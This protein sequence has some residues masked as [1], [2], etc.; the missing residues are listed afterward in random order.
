MELTTALVDWVDVDEQLFLSGGGAEDYQYDQRRDR[1]TARNYFA[2]TPQELRLV[3]GMGDD[4]W[5]SFGDYLT[6]YGPCKLNLAAINQDHW[7]LVEAI[8]RTFAEPTDPVAR[9]ERKLEV[10]AQFVTPMLAYSDSGSATGGSNPNFFAGATGGMAGGGSAQSGQQGQQSGGAVDQFVNM[11]GN[12]T[13]GQ[14][15][16]ADTSDGAQVQVEGVKLRPT[17]AELG[18]E[19]KN[20]VG[21]GK[22]TVFRLEASGESGPGCLDPKRGLCS[23]RKITAIFNTNKMGINALQARQGVWVYWRE[24]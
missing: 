23:R 1:Y 7:P 5:A 8:I 24:E 9:D 21:G 16:M 4:A 18:I 19:L 2:D 3:K 11:V 10:L 17:I 22:K 20:V 12:P 14:S 6:V 13:Q 15:T